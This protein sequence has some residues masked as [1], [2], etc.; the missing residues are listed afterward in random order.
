LATR[1]QLDI[2]GRELRQIDPRGV[3]A[4]EHR[5][6]MAGR[7]LRIESCR[8]R[9]A[10]PAA[11]RRRQALPG[12]GLQREHGAHGLRRAAQAGRGDRHSQ[13]RSGDDRVATCPRRK[14]GASGRGDQSPHAAVQGPRRR[15]LDH[16]VALR[17]SGQPDGGRA[18]FCG[19]PTRT[20]D[21]SSDPEPLAQMPSF[22]G[23]D[24][25]RWVGRM[26]RP[27][28]TAA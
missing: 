20:P 8:R 25:T 26:P 19:D 18:P 1:T 24:S 13:R 2:E 15:R 14:P 11:R 4:F 27:A 9:V 21:W 23:A 22:H 7:K 12:L 3:T 5:F 17:L 10:H 6:D 16:D 28:P